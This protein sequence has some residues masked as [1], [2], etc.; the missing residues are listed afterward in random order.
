MKIKV[1]DIMI[2]GCGSEWCLPFTVTEVINNNIITGIGN[3]GKDVV[4]VMSEDIMLRHLN[5]LERLT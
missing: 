1:G 5:P 3:D 4:Y 2:C